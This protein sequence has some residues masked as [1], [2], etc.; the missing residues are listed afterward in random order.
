VRSYPHSEEV[1]QVTQE[2]IDHILDLVQA[3][4]VLVLGLA[5]ERV[6]E[7]GVAALCVGS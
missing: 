5:L 6:K 2:L 7:Q 3:L 1:L 4:K